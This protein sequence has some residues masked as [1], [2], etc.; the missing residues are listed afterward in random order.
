MKLTIAG[1]VD[2]G[3]GVEGEE[4][5]E[6][7]CVATLARRVDEDRGLLGWEVDCLDGKKSAK[8]IPGR[9]EYK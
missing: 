7:E 1:D 5:R 6:E 8:E 9:C 4:L 3:G 2:D